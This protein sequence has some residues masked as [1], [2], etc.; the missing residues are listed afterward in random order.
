MLAITERLL[1]NY[2][3]PGRNLKDLRAIIIHWT[4]N[5]SRGANAMANR[6]YFNSRDYIRVNGNIIYASAHYVV[7]D[8]TIVRCLPDGEVG[9]HVGSRKPYKALVHNE[10]QIPVGDSPN[11][12]TIGIEMCVN[13][14]GDF[15]K[16]RQHTIELTHHL[17]N[18]HQMHSSQVHRHFDIT[19]KDCPK[20]MLDDVIWKQFLS[21]LENY[22]K[23]AGD[24]KVNVSELNVREGAGTQFPIK[25]KLI[26]G[27]LVNKM[28]QDGL[29]F[30]IGEGE[31]IHSNYVIPA[32]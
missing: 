3:R 20:M 5:T 8:Q 13:S 11:N 16:T 32:G 9:Y 10:L 4:A 27:E 23:P 24:L 17:L 29:W 21:E 12:Y 19:G 7:D 22:N 14:D 15:S 1:N 25:R 26:K 31:W 28:A 30:K 6:N 2:N 18:L